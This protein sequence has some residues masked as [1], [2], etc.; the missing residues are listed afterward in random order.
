MKRSPVPNGP[1]GVDLRCQRRRPA[2]AR[3]VELTERA[4]E[5]AQRP[6]KVRA[7]MRDVQRRQ[8][9]RR[10]GIEHLGI[11]PA[12][13]QLRHMTLRARQTTCRIGPRFRQRLV[14]VD[15]EAILLAQPLAAMDGA[16]GRRVAGEAARRQPLVRR[17]AELAQDARTPSPSATPARAGR[18]RRSCAAGPPA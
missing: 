1:F 17:E 5:V 3:L 14:Q 7:V 6:R 18:S 13:L 4:L 11:G 2:P 12:D 16:P 9:R 8:Q 10:R 15:P